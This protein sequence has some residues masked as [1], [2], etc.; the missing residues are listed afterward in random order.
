LDSALNGTIIDLFVG[1]AKSHISPQS[2]VGEEYR[3]RYIA[4]LILPT[5]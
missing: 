2:I 5:S 3:L 1:Q 4:D